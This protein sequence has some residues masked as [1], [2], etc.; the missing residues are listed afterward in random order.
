MVQ[1][2]LD[3]SLAGADVICGPQE[4]GR[5]RCAQG[6]RAQPSGEPPPAFWGWCSSSFC[7]Q[8]SSRDRPL[9]L[10]PRRS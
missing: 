5:S 4:V 1:L 2:F 10:T 6:D 3:G 9:R 8:L 7:R